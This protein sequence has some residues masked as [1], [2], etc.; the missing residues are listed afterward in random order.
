MYGCKQNQSCRMDQDSGRLLKVINRLPSLRYNDTSSL[1]YFIVDLLEINY[2][3][4]GINNFA[5]SF[6]ITDLYSSFL[7]AGRT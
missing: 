1:A 6:F 3:L 7:L 5:N 4:N 2:L